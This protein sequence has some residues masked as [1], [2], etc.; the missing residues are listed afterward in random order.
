M[1]N[2][3]V[4]S[5]F[6]QAQQAVIHHPHLRQRQVRLQSAGQGKV[7]LEGSVES[8]FEKQMAQEALR[9]IDGYRGDREPI[10]SQLVLI[11]FYANPCIFD[12]VLCQFLILG[13]P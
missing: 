13:L 12:V 11:S 8:Y 9:N 6:Q 2:S 4:F 5:F 10:R 3:T 1:Q 7:T